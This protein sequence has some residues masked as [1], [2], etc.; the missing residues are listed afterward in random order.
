MYLYITADSPHHWATFHSEQQTLIGTGQVESLDE[1]NFAQPIEQVMLVAK[2]SK[3]A[4]HTVSVPGNSRKNVINAIPFVLEEELT[5]DIEDLH[6]ALQSWSAGEEAEVLVVNDEVVQHWLSEFSQ[7]GFEVTDVVPEYLLLPLHPSADITLT[8]QPSGD[9]L[10][11]SGHYAG[12]LIDE[13][14]IELWWDME[15]KDK[16]IAIND[17]KMAKSLIEEGWENIQYW[18]IGSDFSQWIGHGSIKLLNTPC[19]LQGKYD[20]TE[21][22]QARFDYKMA[23]NLLLAGVGIYLGSL[24]LNYAYLEYKSGQFKNKATEIYQ[25]AFPEFQDQVSED[26]LYDMRKAMSALRSGN[27]QSDNFLPILQVV[28]NQL[29]TAPN[30]TL[31]SLIFEDNVLSAQVSVADFAALESLFQKLATVTQGYA[32]V[33]TK[34]AVAQDNTVQGVLEVTLTQG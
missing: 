26:P 8:Q 19:L 34:D 27:Y 23:V 10:I 5:D 18:D 13:N 29:K 30:T 9:Y 32:T 20:D 12:T 2:G 7:A 15:A 11:R 25:V 4:A 24:L 6:F 16:I 31:T 3:V 21:S 1:L 22:R 33:L 14:M 28:A 17:E